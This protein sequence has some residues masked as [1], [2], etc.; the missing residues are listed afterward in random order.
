MGAVSED[1]INTLRRTEM[2][3]RLDYESLRR[4]VE[5]AVE[6]RLSAGEA[7]FVAGEE[8]HGLYVVAE[9]TIRAVRVSSE[10]R[11][12]VIHVERAPTTIA[13]VPAFDDEPS[14]STA[15]SESDALLYFIDKPD[16]RRLCLEHPRMAL[17]AYAYEM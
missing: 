6:R 14:P 4:L 5:R 15:V 17:A 12:R 13:E 16:V 10:G 8:A 7:L 9:G 2:F 1:K 3:G 11:E